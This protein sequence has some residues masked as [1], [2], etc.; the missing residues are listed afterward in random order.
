[1]T[2][3]AVRAGMNTQADWD[4]PGGRRPLHVYPE[5]LYGTHTRV[6][7]DHLFTRELHLAATAKQ[8]MYKIV[9]AFA[10]GAY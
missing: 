1:M 7:L 8:T 9:F 6:F 2:V 10:K 4:L 3:T 5:L